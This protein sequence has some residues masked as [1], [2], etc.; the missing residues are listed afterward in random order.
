MIRILLIFFAAFICGPEC[1][2]QIIWTE[3]AFPTLDDVVTMYYDIAEGNAALANEEPPCPPCPFVYA[4]TGVITSES[5]SPSDWQ[6]V[7]NPWPTGSNN[8]AA[9][10]GNTLLPFDGTVHS[11]DFGG[12]TL[13][14]YYGVPEGVVIEQLAFV[15]R[16]FDGSAVGKTADE[17]DIFYTVSDGSFEVV[18]TNPVGTSSI[19]SVGT[20]MNVIAQ[21]SQTASLTLD[22]NGETVASANGTSLEHSL[23]LSA[24]GDYTIEVHAEVGSLTS[25]ASSAV[26]VLPES[27][28]VLAP[29]A[30]LKD[31]I[32]HLDDNTVILQWTAP[33]KDFVFAV[34]DFNDWTLNGQ[35]L[36]HD[37]GNG[38]T[39]WIQL[40]DL[41]PGQ[42]Y[43]YQ[44]HILPDDICVAD[45][46]AEVILDK[47]ND[48]WIP[49]STYPNLP[50]YPDLQASGPVSV[51]TPGEA[52]FDW[53]DD[54]YVRPDQENLVIY[55]LLVRDF[56]EERTLKFIEDS[57]DY[58]ERLGVQALEL[59]PVNEFN[60]ND[61]WGYNPTFYFAVDKA[62]GTKNDLK[63][64]V[65]ACHERGI[66]VILDVVYNHADQ[67]NPFIT[68]YWEDWTVLPFN[69]WFNTTAPHNF[70]WFHDWN[71]GSSRTRDFVKRNLKFWVDEFHIDGFRWDFSQGI[72]QQQ[73]V[74]GGYNQQ[75]INWLKAYGDHVWN[76]DPTVYM[77]L[78]HW[79]D[80]NEERELADY[81]GMNGDAAGFMLWANATNSYQE[82]SMGYSNN[83]LSWANFQSHN[84]QDRHAVAYAESHDEERLMYKNL[85]MG[86]SNGDYNASEMVIALRR[87]QLS[88]AFNL[89]MPGPRML[90]Q[91]EELGYDYS[92]NTC[93]DGATVNEDC[94]IAAK[95]VR[96]DYYN[97]PERRHLYDVSGALAALK[98][99]YPAFGPSA[100]S[101]NVDVGGG[102]GK[103]MHFEHPDGDAIV[104]GNYKVTAIDMVPGFTHTGTWYDHLTGEALVVSDLNASMPFA[105]GEM[106]VYTDVPLPT[107]FLTEIDV[108]L[109]GQLASEGDCNANDATIYTG[110]VDVANDG[111]DQDCDGT[112]LVS[113]GMLNLSVDMSA[114][115]ISADGV[116][117][118]GNFQGWN[119]SSHQLDSV[120]NGVFGIAIP[121]TEI[122]VTSLEFKFINGN[123]WTAES[124]FIDGPCGNA[125]GNRIFELD[126]LIDS[127]A[128]QAN[129]DGDAFCFNSCETCVEPLAVT[130]NID[131]SVVATV[132]EN[133]VHLAGSFQG[134]D[135]AGTPLSD[136]GDGTWSATVEM[137][138]GTYEFKVINS[139]AWDG[140]EENME[141]SGCNNG[142]NRIA[143]FDA[144][145]N[146]YTACFNTCPGESCTPDPDP[147]DITFRVNMAN[148]ELAEGQAVFVWGGF[149]G[150]QGGAIEMTDADG[151]GIWEHTE[152][153]SGGANVDYKYSIGH[154]ND[155]GVIEEDGVYVLDGDTTNWVAAGCGVDNG[156]GGYNRRHVRSGLAEVLDVVCFNECSDCAGS[157]A[158]VYD[159]T[160]T[161]GLFPNPATDRVVLTGAQGN[162]DVFVLDVQGRE[163]MNLNN[164]ALN[165][166]FE[167]NVAGLEAG[168]YTV[169]I[170][171]GLKQGAQRVLVQ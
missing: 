160:V 17:G 67:P 42:D 154:P 36:M 23:S 119:P 134:W 75:R 88:M 136:N 123:S 127:A 55:E 59:M 108:D 100:T 133:G 121:L 38:E 3:P 20:T 83:D 148:Q 140:N 120:G 158:S 28:P 8:S 170:R 164:A 14:E 32:N 43:R 146:T 13:A 112:D 21:A 168:A 122:S 87:Q 130:F 125:N 159:A 63:S 93:T 166:R 77:I 149:T 151:D 153:I 113:V 82:A 85:Q 61:S 91:F 2:G 106:H 157:D 51:F 53:T 163:V 65:D 73:G 27:A 30:G 144:D 78:E 10:N 60:G 56:S 105:P 147:A 40:D 64:L 142:G 12:L 48:P 114:Q 102:Y 72:I 47:W 129:S 79:C 162:A 4:H 95:P 41:T 15:F 33:Y 57:L 9:N 34:G 103:R 76:D 86:N 117:I 131:M 49:E 71:H 109:D 80:F 45:A 68:M 44:Y 18:L 97:E 19:E 11:F 37:V 155:E 111:I 5:T 116:H 39:F 24:P 96:W 156:F 46:Y 132:S 92:I 98:R 7:H 139:N 145:N 70:T 150:W 1:F 54:S 141:G 62:Y 107:P 99:D 35:S 16:N 167:L 171:Q 110:A 22:V 29:P 26:F 161:F 152:N 25:T 6:Y 165:G 101:F 81:N 126:N 31:G 124:E 118:A 135:P 90:W 138:P 58:L 128:L 66:A 84:F 137:E 89:L 143:T 94:R 169:V 115:E 52:A 69:P 104:V 50:P 74:D